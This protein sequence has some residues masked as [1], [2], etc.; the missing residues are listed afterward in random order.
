MAH[1]PIELLV[2][3]FPGNQFKGEIIPA[4][5]ELVDNG[6]VRIIDLLFVRKDGNGDLTIIEML[7]L[8]E[9][10]REA[11]DPL[12]DDVEGL[13]SEEDAF[14]L[15]AGLEPNSSAGLLLFENTWAARF[16]EAVRN[17]NGEVILSERIPRAV[18]EELEA[19]HA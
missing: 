9:E 3:K 15:A 5:E 10:E 13:L 8:D 14:I 17:A 6:T 1:G 2:L 16:T 18:I 4:M 19:A 7:E 12:V 11:F